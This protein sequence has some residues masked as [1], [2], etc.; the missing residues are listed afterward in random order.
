MAHEPPPLISPAD[1][2]ATP[3]AVQT[4]VLELMTMVRQLSAEVQELRIRVNQTSRNSSKPPSSDPPTAPPPPARRSTG[5]KRG[6]QSGHADQQRPLLPADQVDELVRLHPDACP[7]CHTAFAADVPDAA[8]PLRTQVWELPPIT[9]HVTEYQQRTVTCPTCDHLV[10][11]PCPSARPPGAFGPRLTALIGLL[12]G[13]YRLSTRETAAFLAEVAGVTVSTGSIMRSCDRV[14]VAVEPVDVAI[15]G[16]VAHQPILY[17]DE[18]GW[19]EGGQRGWLWVAVSAVAT[20]FRIDHS[21]S[22]HALRRLIGDAYGGLVHSDRASAYTGL[23]IQ[24]R[25]LCW[26]HLVRNLQGLVDQGHAE[27]RWAQRMLVEARTLFAAWHAYQGGFFDQVALQMALIPV[28][29]AL[30]DLLAI[31]AISPWSKLRKLARELGRYWDALWWFSRVAG[32][33]PTNNVAERALRPAVLWRKSCFGTQ[34]AGG[35]RFVERILSVGATCRQQG[36]T[37]LTFLTDA[38]VAAW[39]GQPAPALFPAL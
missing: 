23:P 29:E 11:A 39:A 2:A 4:L 9:P 37:L 38:V 25:Q 19:R 26:A 14:S 13:R 8:A 10:Q 15:Q 6:A 22:R 27:S 7:V 20:C 24:Q 34:S 28:R 17:V 1:W 36:R 21:R 30:A 35:S 33:E 3:P 16:A 5:R 32:V 31:G 18:T 12:H